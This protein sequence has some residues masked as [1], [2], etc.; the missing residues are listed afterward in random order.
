MSEPQ[1]DVQ[2]VVTL[3]RELVE[4][5]A[6][7]YTERFEADAELFY[8]ETGLMAPGKSM[9]LEMPVS[10]EA[11]D[12]G[13]YEW[14]RVRSERWTRAMSDAAALL[15]NQLEPT[16]W[17]ARF[18]SMRKHSCPSCNLTD[19]RRSEIDGWNAAIAAVVAAPDVQKAGE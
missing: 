1:R 8:R 10:D 4:R 5:Q 2:Y 9:P 14:T 6:M 18:L 19:E 16:D 3:L 15:E 12:S 7:G 13:W 11:R 17:R